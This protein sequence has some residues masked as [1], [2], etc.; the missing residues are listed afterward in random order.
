[1]RYLK[2]AWLAVLAIALVT[3]ALANAD[4]I[5]LRVLPT[6]MAGFLGWSWTIELPLFIV[7]FAAILAGVIIGFIWEWFREHKHRA[8]AKSERRHR[9]ELEREVSQLKTTKSSAP[10]DDVLALVDRSGTA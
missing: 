8:A 6:Q 9:D 5:T 7:I 2:F 4:P 1:M 3:I 10:A